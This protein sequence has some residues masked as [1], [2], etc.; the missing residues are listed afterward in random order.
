MPC[1][2]KKPTIREEEEEETFIDF[3]KNLNLEDFLNYP[4]TADYLLYQHYNEFD[5]H[6][7]E[8]LIGTYKKMCGIAEMYF[9]GILEKDFEAEEGESLAHIVFNN[10]NMK[11]DITIFLDCPALAKGIDTYQEAVYHNPVVAKP[12][13]VEV[14]QPKKFDWVTKTYK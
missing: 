11:T 2:K 9:P 3:L 14:A 13:V 5:Y 10:I 8:A 6:P 1:V 12:S 7:R 4:K